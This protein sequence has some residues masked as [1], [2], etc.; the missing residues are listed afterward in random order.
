MK[1]RG[2]SR[3][4]GSGLGPVGQQFIL[5]VS[6]FLVNM[7]QLPRLH[8]VFTFEAHSVLEPQFPAP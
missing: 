1:G 6:V 7:L 4:T 8:L 2:G 5:M 3:E